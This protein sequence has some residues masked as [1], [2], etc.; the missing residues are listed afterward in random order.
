MEIL[1]DD[2]SKTTLW[3]NYVIDY[4]HK[5]SE[6]PIVKT[7]CGKDSNTPGYSKVVE[8]FEQRAEEI[9]HK[10]GM[11]KMNFKAYQVQDYHD[12][13]TNRERLSDHRDTPSVGLRGFAVYTFRNHANMSFTQKTKQQNKTK[14]Q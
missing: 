11:K 5:G 14:T 3:F 7:K 2:Q 13:Q 8:L 4:H 9:L 6:P 10:L 1:I 12:A